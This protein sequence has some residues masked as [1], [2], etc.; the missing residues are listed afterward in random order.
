VEVGKVEVVASI[1]LGG[2]T[3]VVETKGILDTGDSG[4]VTFF[5]V[6]RQSVIAEVEA[7]GVGVVGAAREMVVVSNSE[8]VAEV[9]WS[10]CKI[11]SDV[12]DGDVVSGVV[13]LV[14]KGVTG[15]VVF[16]EVSDGKDT[17]FVSSGGEVGTGKVVVELRV[18]GGVAVIF[19]TAAA[20]V[21]VPVPTV[22]AVLGAVVLCVT[23]EVSET[24]AGTGLEA[25]V[26]EATAAERVVVSVVSSF[27]STTAGVV[28]VVG[29]SAEVV[30]CGAVVDDC[31]VV[32]VVLKSGCRESGGLVEVSQNRAVIA[33]LVLDVV[34]LN[35]LMVELSG[36]V[37]HVVGP[38]KVVGGV[39][40]TLTVDSGSTTS[41]LT[42]SG[43][44]GVDGGSAVVETSEVAEGEVGTKGEYGASEGVV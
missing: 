43:S 42:A 34:G 28:N 24:G 44:V 26:I 17:V 29:P 14:V 11:L 35:R 2:G 3:V 37:V 23:V 25:V 12:T 19:S 10:V 40:V 21:L 33:L 16:A 22:V 13:L 31:G 41:G 18:N 27:G 9:V 20:F 6:V 7:D 39:S 38:V 30:V 15:V 4:M 1:I 32:G 8:T 36:V 5:V